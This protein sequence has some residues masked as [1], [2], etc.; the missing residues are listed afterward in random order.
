MH[1][2]HGR[3]FKL[4]SLSAAPARLRRFVTVMASRPSRS[5]PTARGLAAPPVAHEALSTIAWLFNRCAV[6]LL[7]LCITSNGRC[8]YVR[9][10][11]ALMR[12]AKHRPLSPS[13]S[14]LCSRSLDVMTSKIRISFTTPV[15][16]WCKPPR[17]E[18]LLLAFPPELFSRFRV[19]RDG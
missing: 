15:V 10:K 11:N 16:S 9:E 12:A 4:L 19:F 3:S 1:A 13:S 14:P 2:R 17:E 6:V 5:E 8:S 7:A 18:T